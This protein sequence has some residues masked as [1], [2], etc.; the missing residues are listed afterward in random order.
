MT[1]KRILTLAAVGTLAA[2]SS[3]AI[4]MTTWIGASAAPSQVRLHLGSDGDRFTNGSTTQSLTVGGNSCA[5]NSA[6][7]TMHL[8]I[9]ELAAAART[10]GPQHR[11]QDRVDE[12]HTVRSGRQYRVVDP[13]SRFR[14]AGRSF[15]SL[16][17]DLEVTGNAIVLVTLRRLELTHVH[18]AD[19]H[20]RQATTEE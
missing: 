18:A 16:R 10:G 11:Y 4:S 7:V 8:R 13:E 1:K 14:A 17:M 9:D 6:E 5:I 2:M 12:R 3:V 19:R 15:T 20:E